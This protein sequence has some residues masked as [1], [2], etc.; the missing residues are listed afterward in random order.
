MLLIAGTA[1]QDDSYDLITNTF[2]G[3]WNTNLPLLLD[4]FNGES[5]QFEENANL[6]PD[7]TIDLNGQVVRIAMFGYKP[8]AFWKEV[9]SIS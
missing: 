4:A 7:K 5:E 9:V 3:R 1:G 2:T 6:F 8:Y